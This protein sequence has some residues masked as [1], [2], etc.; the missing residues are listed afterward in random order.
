MK[1]SDPGSPVLVSAIDDGE[2]RRVASCATAAS[3]S[4]LA[5][6]TGSSSASTASI[7]P[8]AAQPAA[9]DLGLAIVRNVA[10]NHGGDVQ[11]DSREGE[12]STFV[13]QLPRQPGRANCGG[14]PMTETRRVFHEELDS[15]PLRRD[16]ARRARRRGHRSG[17]QRVAGRRPRCGRASRRRRP[18]CSTTSPTTWSSAR[19]CSWRSNS[20][21]PPTCACSSRSCASS[22]RSSASAT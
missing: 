15:P 22:T 3:A 17:D 10:R 7:A 5:I 21:W 19:A 8:A 14:G 11:V 2:T 20:R 6:A 16:P 12:G 18:R 4:R 9:P 1:Y 13:I